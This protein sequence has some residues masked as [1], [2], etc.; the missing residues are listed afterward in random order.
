MPMLDEAKV[1]QKACS[2]VS[3]CSSSSVP[4][5]RTASAS[6]GEAAHAQSPAMILDIPPTYVGLPLTRKASESSVRPAAMLSKTPSSIPAWRIAVVCR[7]LSIWKSGSGESSPDGGGSPSPVVIAGSCFRTWGSAKRAFLS[8]AL[9][10]DP[11]PAPRPRASSARPYEVSRPQ[12]AR[13]GQ[14]GSARSARR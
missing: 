4:P 9:I 10:G 13:H 7:L 14:G 12:A 2:G 1:S 5:L 11:T 3:A 8:V 6:R